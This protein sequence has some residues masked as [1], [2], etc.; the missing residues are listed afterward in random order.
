MRQIVY[1]LL[2]LFLLCSMIAHAQVYKWVDEDGNTQYTDQPPITGTLEKQLRIK[3]APPSAAKAQSDEPES[4]GDAKEEFN[5]R[6]DE[7]LDEKSRMA[8]KAEEDR[9]TC[10]D[11]QGRL[12]M[13]RDSPR[14]TMPDG[15]GGIVYVDDDQRD[16]E[17][18]QAN[19]IIAKTCK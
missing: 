8:A 3:S 10:I 4:L 6:R 13:F 16:A 5:N 11:A 18:K 2:F 15:K 14:L 1:T 12:K 19:A 9:L 17:I 7:R